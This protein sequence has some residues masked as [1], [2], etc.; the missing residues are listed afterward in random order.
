M[1][2]T[3]TLTVS[4]SNCAA[5]AC[6]SRSSLMGVCSGTFRPSLACSIFTYNLW[7]GTFRA[8]SLF[9]SLWVNF[10]SLSALITT[11]LYSG[12]DQILKSVTVVS[13]LGSGRSVSSGWVAP[14]PKEDRSC[15]SFPIISDGCWYSPASAASTWASFCVWYSAMASSLRVN[16]FWDGFVFTSPMVSSLRV[17]TF[18]DC[19]IFISLLF[20]RGLEMFAAARVLARAL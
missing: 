15:V 6:L 1:I 2:S 7:N 20:C 11:L 13:S 4:E 19:F 18:W 10:R 8:G 5:R 3:T 12:L 16:A 9:K 17:C 14:G